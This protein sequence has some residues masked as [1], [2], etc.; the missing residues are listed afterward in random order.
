MLNTKILLMKRLFFLFLFFST[1]AVMAQNAKVVSAY[2]SL[3]N[4]DL[5]KAVEYIESAT[6]HDKTGVD[7]KTW[8]YRGQIYQQIAA[9]EETFNIGKKEAIEI[10]YRSFKKSKELDSRNRWEGELLLGF[11]QLKAIALHAGI[12]AY[13]EASYPDARDLFLIGADISDDLEIVDTLAIYNA[14]LAAEQAEDY[15]VAVQQYKKAIDLGYLGPNLYLY[16]A[17]MYQNQD[18]QE[19]YI[20]IVRSG[21]EAYPDNSDL[22]IYELNY[23][24]R[25]ER[26]EE[27]EN[28]LKLAIEKEPDNK[29]LYFSL[30]F[31]YDRLGR[32]DD[33]KKYYEQAI[34]LDDE[35]FDPIF[36]LG[37]LYFNQGV[38]MNNAA[39]EIQDNKKYEAAREEARNVFRK[40]QPYFEKAHQLD[41]SELDVIRSLAQLYAL[42]GKN[43]KFQE[44]KDKENA[45]RGQ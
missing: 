35:Y 27:A 12:E 28:N 2:N 36:N 8:L 31:V 32:S 4:G 18:N 44:M 14:G 13:N 19:E 10:A 23:Y 20:D 21:R 29:Q 15:D 42:L 39:N 5:N 34:D 43:D 9:S 30:G 3:R 22:I 16:L 6:E 7:P 24:L 37:A 25:N 45:L 33:A 11:Q 40:A 1:T 17:N 26:L 38:E 41:A